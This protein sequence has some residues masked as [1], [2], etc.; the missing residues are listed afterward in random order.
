MSINNWTDD[1][2]TRAALGSLLSYGANEVL[3]L[4]ARVGPAEAWQQLKAG[5]PPSAGDGA[6]PE[7]DLG[8]RP[9]QAARTDGGRR[10]A[11]GEAFRAW[12]A[13]IVPQDVAEQTEKFGLRFIV[14][15]DAEWPNALDDLAGCDIDHLGGLPVGLWV[16]GPGHLA[17]WCDDAVA[18]VGSRSATRYGESVAMRLAS[19]LAGEPGAHPWTIVSGGAFGIDAASHRGALLAGGRTIGVFANGLDVAYPPGNA[20][21]VASIRQLGLAVSELPPGAHPTRHGFLARN[22]VIAALSSGT[23]VVEAALRSGARNTAS[24]AS[25]MGRLVMG[26]PG[27]VTSAMSVT[28]HR[29]IRDGEATLVSSTDDIRALLTPIGQGPELPFAGQVRRGDDLSGDDKVVREALPAR[30]GMSVSEV[31][32]AAGVPVPRCVAALSRLSEGGFAVTDEQGRWRARPL[33][34]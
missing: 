29:L 28:P 11:G 6:S 12:T 22:R 9:A 25:A 18:L 8:E 26:V 34:S 30:G 27:P 14:P 3:G 32:L 15:G 13:S 7:L 19:E 17:R 4:A 31:V 10:L 21:L 2:L 24:W 16:T 5:R 1:R 20:S 33:T 23:V